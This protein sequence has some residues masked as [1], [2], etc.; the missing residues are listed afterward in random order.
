MLAVLMWSAAGALV[1]Y[2]GGI[3]TGLPDEDALRG[4][5][6]MARATTVFDAHDRPAFAIFKEQRIEVP[7]SRVS[8]H[9]VNAIVAVEDQRFFDHGGIDV[10]RIAG[11]AWKNLL[12]GWGTQ[13]G[14]TITQQLARQSFL[15]RDKTVRRKVME[16]VVAARLED[17]FTKEQILEMYL[18]KV[19]F[20][21][22]LYGI[23]AASL[24]YFG[25]HAADVDLAEAALLAG[26]VKAP[27]TYAPTVSLE[28]AVAARNAALLAM[29]AAG[30]IDRGAYDE[31]VRREVRLE[32]ALRAQEPFG[33]YFKE[34]VRKQLVQRF[35]WE[36]VYQGGLKVYTTLDLDLQ[37]AAEAEV[38]RSLEEIER[39]QARRRR[40]AA[41][42]DQTLQAALVSLDP[43]TGEVR[44]M[45]G[46]RSFHQ[47]PFNRATQA[48]RQPG[49]AFKPFVYA[50]ALERGFTP[51]SLL[52]ALDT[53]VMTVE[54]AWVPEDH[55]TGDAM[56][57]R[58]A[59]RSS[60]NRAAVRMLQ[61]VG[62]AAAVRYAERLGVGTVPSVPSLALGS[63][64]V[65]LMSMA[66]AYA[67][68]ASGGLLPTPLLIRR[69]ES[70]EGE[71]LSTASPRAERA[72]SEATAFLMTTM[73]ADVVDAGTAW[74]ARRVGFRL[75]AAGKTGTTNDSRDAWFVG[76]TPRL[77]TGVWVGYD[78]PRTIIGGGYAGDLAVP[79]WGRFMAVATRGHGAEPFRAPGTVTTA[80]I[81]RISGKLATEDCRD[82]ET[83]DRDGYPTRQSMV[84][85][86]YFVRGTEPHEY[87]AGHAHLTPIRGP[88]AEATPALPG[89]S[90]PLAPGTGAAVATPDAPP[91]EPDTARTPP[92]PRPPGFWR[93]LFGF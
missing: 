31:A 14:S 27:S 9:V 48:R 51:A 33:Q 66:A 79:L 65:T 13:G 84:V 91:V 7:L 6:A 26:L 32:D 58:A 21:D 4:I 70:A 53:P 88:I 38:Q 2:L 55:S 44:A 81:C 15:S 86:E 18:N 29:R 63:G 83:V 47:S 42:D 10:I 43:R 28:R 90:V 36:R 64:E 59:M 67:A 93:R 22:G 75:P 57:I 11:A 73:M 25:K 45:V 87:C 68:F 23:E 80:A 78:Q 54:G 92:Q 17:E 85:T 39:R 76:Y 52:T 3:L 30:I 1:W 12:D 82:V 5:G 20:G 24:G 74:Q 72:V 77:A 62:L 46:G 19:Y 89:T 71:Q 50:A 8:P 40:H 69:V 60:S 16:V 35:G 41:A 49:S 61:E 56:T 37:K 34:E